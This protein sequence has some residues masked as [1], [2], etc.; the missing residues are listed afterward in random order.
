MK[1][2]SLLAAFGV[3]AL[4]VVSL[5][6]DACTR[7]VYL[8]PDGMTVTGRTM[9]W[10]EDPRTNLYVFPRGI[11]RRGALS[12]H[13]VF[14]KSKYGSVSAAGY[15]IGIAD[16]MNEAGL[17]ASLLFL[18]ES[19]YT[20]PNDDRP[21]MGLSIW[22]QY[23]LDNFATVSE[24]VAELRK[25]TFRI[26][27]PDLPNGVQSRLHLAVTDASGDTA[28]FEYIDGYLRIHEG[29]QYQVMTN[30]P[31]YDLQLAVNDYWREIGGTVMLPGTNRSSDRFV[32]A[33]FYINAV[34]Q[35]ADPKIAVPAVFSVMR[36]VSVPYGITTPDKPNIASTR[37]RSV[38]DQKQKVYYFEPTLGMEIFWV[39]L[40]TV[41][42]SEGAPEMKLTLTGGELYSGNAASEFRRTDRP[43]A[44]LFGV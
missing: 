7:A 27:A 39:D 2:T 9:D 19:D 8:G 25:E 24:A 6:S 31:S 3:C 20:R 35:S 12:D 21:V 4:A 33:S 1:K 22:T 15:D 44:F 18:P 38:C 28:V 42:F 30:S 34:E 23:V 14:W 43:F 41:D 40:S 36:N 13:T 16:G 17:V 29:R 11:E 5:P 32:R 37:W 10:R 26:D